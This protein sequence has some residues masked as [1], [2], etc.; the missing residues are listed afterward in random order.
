V[1]PIR[2]LVLDRVRV[3]TQG[4]VTTLSKWLPRLESFTLSHL[5]SKAM[6]DA[7]F[8]LLLEVFPRLE[9]LD[10]DGLNLTAWD[11][12]LDAY[13]TRGC[14]VRTLVVWHGPPFRVFRS[15]RR[16]RVRPSG[17]RER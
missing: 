8:R 17:S 5:R 2:A 9:C 16:S 6:D 15:C 12:L 3:L 13:E 7:C 11:D 4:A 1:S 14:R 10:I